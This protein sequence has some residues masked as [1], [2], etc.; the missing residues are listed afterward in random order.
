[1][2]A[3]SHTLVLGYAM[4]KSGRSL[5]GA[6]FPPRLLLYYFVFCQIVIVVRHMSILQLL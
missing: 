3:S 5:D 4:T 6:I 2:F 1:M